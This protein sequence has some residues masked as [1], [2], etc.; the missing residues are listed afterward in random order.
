V[1]LGSLLVALLSGIEAVTRYG[2]S[3]NQ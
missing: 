3:V 1:C 2:Q